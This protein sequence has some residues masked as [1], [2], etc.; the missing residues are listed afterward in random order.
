MSAVTWVST[1]GFIIARLFRFQPHSRYFCRTDIMNFNQSE[2][3]LTA[4]I[5]T[6]GVSGQLTHITQSDTFQVGSVPAAYLISW[7]NL[8]FSIPN[9]ESTSKLLWGDICS[10]FYSNVLFDGSHQTPELLLHQLC[11]YHLPWK[12]NQRHLN[13]KQQSDAGQN[14]NP[15]YLHE[16]ACWSNQIWMHQPFARMHAGNNL[17]TPARS[18]MPRE[19]CC[20][21]MGVIKK[22]SHVVDWL[23]SK[24]TQVLSHR[25]AR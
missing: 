12:Q 8:K 13:Q 15:S 11:G 20:I 7:G 4:S 5:N 14:L 18:Q 17:W 10:V 3:W 16:L 2:M 25:A 24:L 22:R 23:V 9:R 1:E 6:R 19:V 21:P